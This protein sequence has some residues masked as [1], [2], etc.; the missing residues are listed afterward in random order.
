MLAA[1]FRVGLQGIL[2][3]G[4]FSRFTQ[5]EYT[6]AFHQYQV[7]R[8]PNTEY[9]QIIPVFDVLLGSLLFSHRARPWAALF[10]ALAQGAGVVKRLQ[11]GQDVT[12]DVGIFTVAMI[13]FSTSWFGDRRKR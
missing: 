6:P 1:I 3:Y 8:A 13:V 4:A 12:P 10:V 5:G 11:E 2:Y 7:E 9:T